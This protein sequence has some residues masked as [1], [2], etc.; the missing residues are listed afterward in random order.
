[1]KIRLVNTI[2]MGRKS[3]VGSKGIIFSHRSVLQEFLTTALLTELFYI[4]QIE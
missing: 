1:M 3:V 4:I 2:V